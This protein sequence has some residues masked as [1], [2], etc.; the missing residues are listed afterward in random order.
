MK[1]HILYLAH[2]LADAAIRRRVLMLI[3]GGA[4]VTVAGFQRAEN[5]LDGQADVQTIA[6]GR[7]EDARFVQR[8]GAVVSAAMSLKSRLSG[9]PRP[10]VIVARNVEMLALAA[11]ASSVFGGGIPV[12]YECLDIHRLL[13]DRGLKGT[14]L[15]ALEGYFGRKA[16]LLVTSSPAFV[17]HYFKPRSTLDLPTLLLENK[18]LELSDEPHTAAPPP[19][20]RTGEPWRIG[21]FGAIRCR[22][23]LA[24][25][26]DFAARMN[27]RVEI[28]M[29]GRP[30]DSEFENF[31]RT[32]QAAPFVEFHGAYRNPEDLGSIYADVHFVWAIDFFEEGLNSDWLL[33]NRLYEGS[34]HGAIPI[35]LKST[36]T[37]KFLDQRNLGLTLDRV[38]PEDLL[39]EFEAMTPARYKE[40]FGRMAE[41]ERSTW[42]AGPTDCRA[43]V[44][45]LSKLG[46]RPGGA[47]EP[48]PAAAVSAGG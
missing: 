15:R 45:K 23:S 33:P 17:E 26:S 18:V 3:S 24:I 1:T 2:D 8:I 27:G 44:T 48:F 41:T 7:T 12:V 4:S 13:L 39:C 42:V 25:L 29:R 30:A 31:E 16:K 37:G 46:D 11:R 5:L 32:V 35:A 19:A 14:L 6:L 36:E 10:D 40:L 34:V 28:V 47:S 9:V 21:W 20:P 22:K 43:L 38:S